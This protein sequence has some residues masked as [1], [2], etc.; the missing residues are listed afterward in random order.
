ML[1]VAFG[2]SRSLFD[3]LSHWGYTEEPGSLSSG[4][5]SIRKRVFVQQR[6]TRETYSAFL[7]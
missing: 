1:E 2:G 7:P 5:Q 4:N 6:E 3:F